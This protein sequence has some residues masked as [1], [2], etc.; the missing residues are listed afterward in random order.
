M[1]RSPEWNSHSRYADV[2][3]M[4][5]FSNPVIAT[6]ESIIIWAEEECGFFYYNYFTIYGHD[7]DILT[8]NLFS[9]VGSTWNLE[10]TGQVISE[11]K[12]FNNTIIYTCILHRG[13]GR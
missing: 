5:H 9:T 10:E 8:I 3:G 12:E 13:K 7:S 6:N 2:T 4:Q 11:E 1:A